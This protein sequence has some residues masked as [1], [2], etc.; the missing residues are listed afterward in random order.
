M[1]LKRS[2][3]LPEEYTAMS[4]DVFTCPCFKGLLIASSQRTVGMPPNFPYHTRRHSHKK[5]CG[6]KS[7][8]AKTVRHALKVIT[9]HFSGLSSISLY[10]VYMETS[11]QTC[12]PSLLGYPSPSS[13]FAVKGAASVFTI[14]WFFFLDLRQK[15][16]LN[17]FSAEGILITVMLKL[18][19]L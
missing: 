7:N 19:Q 16:I 2:K 5:W 18:T 6:S 3:F 11:R 9:H 13:S 15:N 10:M 4:S 1:I 14:L 17:L 12:K 8:I